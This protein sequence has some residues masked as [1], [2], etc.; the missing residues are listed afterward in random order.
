MEFR[1]LWRAWK[2]RLRDEREEIHALCSSIQDGEMAVDVGA[3]K[4]SY[5]YWLSRAAGSGTVVAF[6]PQP[7]LAH[8]LRM[9]RA[10]AGLA[11]VTVEAAGVSDRQGELMLHVPGDATRRERRLK[12]PS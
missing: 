3:N 10:P 11:N 7:E 2:A 6:E 8:Y 1:F 5:L 9:H 4:G 12:A